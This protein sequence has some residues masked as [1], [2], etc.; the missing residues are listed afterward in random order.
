VI[1]PGVSVKAQVQQ[2]VN[3]QIAW[4]ATVPQQFPN[5]AVP[6]LA[7]SFGAP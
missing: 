1:F 6:I 7:G 5:L 4:E 3:R 2:I